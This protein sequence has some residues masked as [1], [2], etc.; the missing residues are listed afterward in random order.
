MRILPRLFAAA[1][2]LL[3]ASPAIAASPTLQWTR[4]YGGARRDVAATVAVAAGEGTIWLRGVTVAV[5]ADGSVYVAGWVGNPGNER[6]PFDIVKYSGSGQRLWRRTVAHGYAQRD[7]ASLDIAGDG[8]IGVVTTTHTGLVIARFEADG[9]VR[10]APVAVERGHQFYATAFTSGGEVCA[11]GWNSQKESVLEW[12]APDGAH[13]RT[14][15]SPEVQLSSYTMQLAFAPDGGWY[16]AWHGSDRSGPRSW[17]VVV[18]VGAAG[19]V[20]WKR[21]FGSRTGAWV[22][23]D[24][25]AVTPDGGLLL[26]GGLK[27]IKIDKEHAVVIKVAPDGT[28]TWCRTYKPPYGQARAYG[29]AAGRSGEVYVTGASHVNYSRSMDLLQLLYDETGTLQGAATWNGR[30][31]GADWGVDAAL[32]PDG[33]VYLVGNTEVPGALDILVQKYRWSSGW[34]TGLAA[35]ETVSRPR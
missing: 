15:A 5:A 24:D 29:V 11:V 31:R 16:V 1:F 13:L 4:T 7:A 17:I 19:E 8:S 12:F 27:R 10:A 22:W 3:A 18:R 25:I 34:G 28:R 30:F 2:V 6:R 14:W 9:A 21:V 26:A 23:A 35:G 33:D 32:A 20:L